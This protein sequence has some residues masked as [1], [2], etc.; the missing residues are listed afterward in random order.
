MAFRGSV[1][2]C[3]DISQ[4]V[5]CVDHVVSRTPL[6]PASPSTQGTWQAVLDDLIHG[7]A[8]NIGG[9]IDTPDPTALMLC[10]LGGGRR[11]GKNTSLN[12]RTRMFRR[13]FFGGA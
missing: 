6:P 7:M 13:R 12:R 5:S 9:L 3:I 2:F 1:F 8:F 4:L 10:L 11:G